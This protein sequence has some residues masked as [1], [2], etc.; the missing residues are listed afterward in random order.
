MKL[1]RV[2]FLQHRRGKPF[3]SCSNRKIST[4]S[5]FRFLVGT[6]MGNEFPLWIRMYEVFLF[7]MKLVHVLRYLPF[8]LFFILSFSDSIFHPVPCFAGSWS[9]LLCPKGSASSNSSTI[10]SRNAVIEASVCKSFEKNI[11][12][13]WQWQ[14]WSTLW[15]GVKWLSGLYYAHSTIICLYF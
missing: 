1:C 8:L 12:S 10:W 13:L 6:M 3:C 15:W 2:S 14:G 11:H 5:M 7:F 9:V 4:S